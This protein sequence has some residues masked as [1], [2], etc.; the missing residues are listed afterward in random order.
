[1]NVVRGT[2]MAFLL[3][4]YC[5]FE[6]LP[7]RCIFVDLIG[8]FLFCLEVLVRLNGGSVG[9]VEVDDEVDAEEDPEPLACFKKGFIPVQSA[10]VADA[11]AVDVV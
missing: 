3:L 2:S 9:D 5:I 7:H 6:R 8:V 11:E 4:S 10:N 1:M